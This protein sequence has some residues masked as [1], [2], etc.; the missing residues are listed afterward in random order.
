MLSATNATLNLVAP[1]LTSMAIFIM[2]FFFR[3]DPLRRSVW[4]GVKQVRLP[5]GY[6]FVGHLAIFWAEHRA[7]FREGRSAEVQ[8]PNTIRHQGLCTRS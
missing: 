3:I 8:L 4:L 1:L 5:D 2:L 7:N 6:L